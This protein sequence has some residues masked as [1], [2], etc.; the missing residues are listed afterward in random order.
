MNGKRDLVIGVDCSTTACKA[1]VWDRHGRMIA[2]G[3]SSLKLQMPRASWHEQDAN[4]WQRALAAALRQA[5]G[6]IDVQTL[7]ALSIAHQR[8]TFVLVDDDVRPLRPAIVWM[9][10]RA[11]SLLPELEDDPGAD[12]IHATTGKPLSG[13]LSLSKLLW[14]QR[15]DA[16]TLRGARHILDVHAFLVHRLTGAFQTGWGCADPMGLFDMRRD[17][18]AG[19]LL[20]RVG[21]RLDQMPAAV[22]PGEVVGRVHA[23]AAKACGLREGLPVVAGLGDGQA[24]GL[25]A[26]AIAPGAAYLNLGTAVVS[27]TFSPTYV[28]SRAFRTM[29]GGVPGSYLL[30]TVILG[31]AYTVSW[32]VQRFAG[33]ERTGAGAAE[34]RLDAEASALPPGSDG[35]LLVPYWNSAMNPFWDAGASGIV[36]GWRGVHG[37]AHFYRAILEGIAFEQ[38]LHSEG[39]AQAL[40]G[41]VTG[42]TAMGGGARSTLWRQ[43]VADVTGKPVTRTRTAE[44]AALGAGILAAVG[45]G[46]HHDVPA[47]VAAMAHY[48]TAPMC[49]HEGRHAAY[50]RLYEDVYRGLYPAL[51]SYL[52]RLT[53]LAESSA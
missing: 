49:P 2:E 4:T 17:G 50:S 16:E 21:A 44:A 41:D 40:G 36:A 8:E 32:F 19:D 46:L 25:G 29:Y 5:V 13:N 52:A 18:W 9:D 20:A 12:A 3:R 10:E 23:A 27:G 35:L 11:R 30:E 1:I 26:G 47:A 42:Y 24:A 15:H 34:R 28:T 39:V 31:G 7:A 33:R 45:A 48:E 37:R 38:R 51:R 53:E 22:P 6:G 43:I 14:L